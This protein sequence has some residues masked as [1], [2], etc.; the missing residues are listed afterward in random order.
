MDTEIDSYMIRFQKS[1]SMS[2]SD[3]GYV[4]DTVSI[5]C[6]L[7]GSILGKQTGDG[8]GFSTIN[9]IKGQNYGDTNPDKWIN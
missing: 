7:L 6:D 1:N 3:L 9:R 2:E 4:G 5:G 8:D